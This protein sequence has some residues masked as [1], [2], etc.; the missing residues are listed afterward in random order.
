MEET[1]SVHSG[2]RRS[3]GQCSSIQGF[4]AETSLTYLL[5]GIAKYAGNGCDGTIVNAWKEA[6]K[7]RDAP[8]PLKIPK[9]DGLDAS[10]SQMDV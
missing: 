8:P 9:F 10:V 7:A 2:G 3:P 6:N 5:A 4:I 1:S